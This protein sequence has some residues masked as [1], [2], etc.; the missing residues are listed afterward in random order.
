M[1]SNDEMTGAMAS[2][3]DQILA[4]VQDHERTAHAGAP[5]WLNRA[6]ALAY[7]AHCLGIHPETPP[8]DYVSRLAGEYDEQCGKHCHGGTPDVA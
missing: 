4:I 7:L 1:M 3:R 5:C 6:S 2:V 8:W